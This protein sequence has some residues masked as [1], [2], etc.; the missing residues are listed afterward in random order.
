MRRIFEAGIAAALTLTST[1]AARAGGADPGPEPSAVETRH[2]TVTADGSPAGSARQV[3]RTGPG[4]T[5]EVAH[6]MA[7]K[8]RVFGFT[9]RYAHEGTE[10]WRGGRLVALTSTT[11]DNGTARSL[12]VARSGS[13]LEATTGRRRWSVP[14]DATTDHFFFAPPA[15]RPGTLTVIETEQGEPGRASLTSAGKSKHKLADGRELDCDRYRAS[16]G[17]EADLWFDAAGRVVRQESVQGGK[18]IVMALT[19]VER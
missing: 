14:A 17:V 9:Y 7:L 4:G 8:L 15:D 10:R 19:E 13:T 1:S 18:R 6:A 2:Y 3:Y 12:E 11:D 5:V 16:G